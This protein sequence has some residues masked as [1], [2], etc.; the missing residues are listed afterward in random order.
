MSLSG[1]SELNLTDALIAAI[2]ANDAFAVQARLDAGADPCKY[3]TTPTPEF[4][5]GTP[6]PLHYALR[7]SSKEIV[8]LLL[9]KSQNLNLDSGN[10]TPLMIA[11]EKG[12]DDD[13]IDA[14]LKPE[15][16]NTITSQGTALHVC[17][18]MKNDLLFEKMIRMRADIH[19]TNSSGYTPLHQV[20][21]YG[22]L[23]M[24]KILLEK[25]AIITAKDSLGRTP[26]YYICQRASGFGGIEALR[27]I[28]N[29][30]TFE[31]DAELD[32]G[33]TLLMTAAYSGSKPCL[34]LL[35]DKGADPN[36][37]GNRGSVLDEALRPYGIKN[38]LEIITLL[39]SRGAIPRSQDREMASR[40]K[41]PLR[42]KL[43]NLYEVHIA[44]LKI[45]SEVLFTKLFQ[46][47]SS[48]GA[49]NTFTLLEKPD[50]ETTQLT[51]SLQSLSISSAEGSPIE[52]V[53]TAIVADDS[54]K[55]RKRALLIAP[56]L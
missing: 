15:T 51:F 2:K 43:L 13:I 30:P 18:R 5:Y 49:S 9:T 8:S 14:L 22:T 39:L 3:A 54:T 40:Q 19:A 47:L 45:K 21:N 42:S 6:T 35:L 36:Y 11:I 37:T 27:L 4:G 44:N 24:L 32:M 23:F 48:N 50:S 52:S 16:I 26:A 41:E 28:V 1:A 17:I 25:G 46:L 55:E 20:G 34:S 38:P 53:G 10:Y 12:F 29:L 33:R 31:I 7:L 56:C